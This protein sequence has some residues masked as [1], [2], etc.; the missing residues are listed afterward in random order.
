MIPTIPL[1]SLFHNL[2][3][4]FDENV[5]TECINDFFLESHLP[6]NNI[7]LSFS[8][9]NIKN[10]LTDLC[11]NR[12]LQN[13]FENSLREIKLYWIEI[14]ERFCTVVFTLWGHG[15]DF[16]EGSSTRRSWVA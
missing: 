11:G 10:R 13:E 5:F 2:D 9:A 7:N 4:W 6:H 8:I 16:L 1:R 3:L 12:D 15:S 14:I